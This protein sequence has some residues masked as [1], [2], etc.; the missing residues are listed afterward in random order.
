MSAP[1]PVM[2][3]LTPARPDPA[4]ARAIVESYTPTD[5]VDTHYKER[6]LDL[7][8]RYPNDFGNRYNYDLGIHGH[9]TSQ[10]FVLNPARDAVALLHH[11]KLD[12]WI[13]QGGHMEPGDDDF[14]AT[15]LRE[16]EEE[17]G[18]K[19]LQLV[20]NTPFDLDIHGFPAR[21]NQ[22]DHIHYDMRFLFVASDDTLHL[23]TDE[24]VHLEWVKIKNLR[25]KMPMWLSNSRLVAR[26]T[27]MI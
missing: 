5:V 17:A 15:A 6:Y 19:N 8:A 21:G 27:A 23:N 18:F 10:A 1:A 24:G 14:I 25:D 16:A 9:I 22:P 13:G 11:K 4:R 2:P 26:L 7:I 3:P 20:Q 12:I